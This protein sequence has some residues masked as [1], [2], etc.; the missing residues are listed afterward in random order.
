[1]MVTQRNLGRIETGLLERRAFLASHAASDSD[2]AAIGRIDAALTRIRRGTYG[3]CA[4][5][6]GPI[7][8]LRLR[9]L[10]ETPLCLTCTL[11]RS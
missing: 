5:C 9:K 2:R 8:E 11:G 1:M 10:P 6:G 3:C 7:E 4:Q